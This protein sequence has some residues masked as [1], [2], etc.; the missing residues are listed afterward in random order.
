MGRPFYYARTRAIACNPS[1]NAAHSRVRAQLTAML[2]TQRES[3][4]TL[5]SP[6]LQ[7]LKIGSKDLGDYGTKQIAGALATNTKQAKQS[8]ASKAK[9]VKQSKASSAKQSQQSKA[10]QS[11]AKQATQSKA[12]RSKAKQ[13]QERRR[14]VEMRGD[15]LIPCGPSGTA[16][17]SS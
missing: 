8:K 5:Q 17:R 16:R 1:L 15:A 2:I 6:R 3:H 9:Q 12:Q 11:N 10:K 4:C 13:S 14:G 7:V